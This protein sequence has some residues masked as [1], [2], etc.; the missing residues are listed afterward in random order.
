MRALLLSLLLAIPFA[1]PLAQTSPETVQSVI[2]VRSAPEVEVEAFAL[3]PEAVEDLDPLARN[4]LITA[5]AATGA[6]IA[7]GALGYQMGAGMDENTDGD[8][9]FISEK[10]IYGIAILGTAASGLAAHLTSRQEDPL[11]RTVLVP[12]AVQGV[13]I[14]GAHAFL[15]TQEGTVALGAPPVAVVFSTSM[16]LWD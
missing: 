12:L 14:A 2:V 9:F 6:Y 16:A 1:T 7:G 3:S 4:V 15:S 11:W 8:E 13:F 10:G 5:L